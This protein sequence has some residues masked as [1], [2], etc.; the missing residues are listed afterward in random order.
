MKVKYNLI[1]FALTIL[2]IT[3]MTGDPYCEQV[4]KN[5]QCSGCKGGRKLVYNQCIDSNGQGSSSG[6]YKSWGKNEYEKDSTV[7]RI[8]AK[9]RLEYNLNGYDLISVSSE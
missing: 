8:D 1:V 6:N 5:G 9:C 2:V 4:S 3:V 7:K